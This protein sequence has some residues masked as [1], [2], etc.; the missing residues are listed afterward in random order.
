MNNRIWV[1]GAPDPEMESIDNLLRE[2][3][4][5]VAYATSGGKRVHPGNAYAADLPADTR[6]HIVLVECDIPALNGLKANCIDAPYCGCVD[7]SYVPASVCRVDHHRPGD[8]GYGASPTYY[9]QASS[10]GQV[11]CILDLDQTDTASLVAAADHCLG[12]AY[13]GDCPG[14]NPDDLMRWRVETRAGFQNRS[15]ES[16]AA[17]IVRAQAIL[18]SAKNLQ[19]VREDGRRT[20][21]GLSSIPSA[22]I[23]IADLLNPD[24]GYLIDGV[25]PELP[26]AAAREGRAYITTLPAGKDGRRKVVLQVASRKQVE[27]FLNHFPADDK[28]GDPARGFAGGLLI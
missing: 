15:P 1:L 21:R 22:P 25:I 26:E 8:L 13:C 16:L 5:A 10:I 3:G 19:A 18:R 14:I 7:C 20:G 9:W 4:E 27:W 24:H 6:G 12:A 2:Q 28:Y 17:D 11:H 23:G